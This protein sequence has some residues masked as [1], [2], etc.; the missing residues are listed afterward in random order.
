[1]LKSKKITKHGG[2]LI[3]SSKELKTVERREIK[4]LICKMSSLNDDQKIA[5]YQQVIADMA[6]NGG[7]ITLALPLPTAQLRI[8]SL[9]PFAKSE[10]PDMTSG[11]HPDRK[12]E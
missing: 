3:H 6:R 9:P 12:C 8:V 1:M 7:R 2:F 10:R 5:L 11:P 4:A